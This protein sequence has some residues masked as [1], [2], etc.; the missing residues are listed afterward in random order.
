MVACGIGNINTTARQSDRL[1]LYIKAAAAVLAEAE[2][3]LLPR[4][5][6]YG[7]CEVVELIAECLRSPVIEVVEFEDVYNLVYVA[8]IK[9]GG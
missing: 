2:L 6:G 5:G 7:E 8:I 1:K 9:K 3:Q 4:Q